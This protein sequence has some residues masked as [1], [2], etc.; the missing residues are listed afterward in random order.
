MATT[1][2]RPI[3]DIQ[4][5]ILEEMVATHD[6]IFVPGHRYGRACAALRE[7]GLAELVPGRHP[8]MRPWYRITDAGRSEVA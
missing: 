1:A 7:R 3:T 5:R 8:L 4:R 2:P 6:G